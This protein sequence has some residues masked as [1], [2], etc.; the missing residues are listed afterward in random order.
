MEFDRA[1]GRDHV[2]SGSG[3][4]S[5][6]RGK[7]TGVR[8]LIAN[9]PSIYREVISSALEELRPGVEVFT[10]EPDDLEEEFLRLAPDLVVC[11]RTTKRVELD[12]PAWVEL[13][14]DGA[15]YAIVRNLDG[16]RRTLSRIGFDN[17]LSILDSI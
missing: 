15:P 10:A 14:P 16:S 11:S 4:P 17:L 8:V 9:E 1:S 12:A 2:P 6:G 7:A 3:M 5:D 13:Y